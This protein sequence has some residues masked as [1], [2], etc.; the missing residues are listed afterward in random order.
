MPNLKFLASIVREILGGGPKIPKVGHVT[1][2][3]P[4]VKCDLSRPNFASFSLILTAIH[5]CAKFE[6]FSFNRSRDIRGSQNPKSESCDPHMTRFDLILQI[7]GSAPCF[8]SVC[9]IGR[10]Y[11]HQWPTYGYYTTSQIWLRNAYSGQFLGV[12]GDFDP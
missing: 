10:K 1:P 5:L 7:L 12:F 11:L 2:T 3:W 6:V 9:E 8:Q 4:F